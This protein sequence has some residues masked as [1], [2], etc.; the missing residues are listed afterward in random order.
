MFVSVFFF[1]QA[2][3]GIRDTSVTGAQTCAL[4]ILTKEAHQLLQASGLNFIGAAEREV[5]AFDVADEVEPR[6][7]EELVRFLRHRVA[8]LRLLTDAEQRSEER[9][10][11]EA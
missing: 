5:A 9:R 1:F 6:G 2:E 3:D 11:G 8:L 7:L 10:V 4:P